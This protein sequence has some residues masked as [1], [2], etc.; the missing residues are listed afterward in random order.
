MRQGES[1]FIRLRVQSALD[2]APAGAAP[3]EGFER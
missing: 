2:A 1:T 3:I